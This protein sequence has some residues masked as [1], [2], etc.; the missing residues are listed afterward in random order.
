MAP[1]REEPERGVSTS[2]RNS[3]GCLQTGVL[4]C[5]PA[6][7][8]RPAVFC[9]RRRHAGIH[10]EPC[11][12]SDGA[13]DPPERHAGIYFSAPG[14]PGSKPVCQ[15]AVAH[16]RPHHELFGLPNFFRRLHGNRFG[17]AQLLQTPTT[18][19]YARCCWGWWC[20]NAGMGEAVWCVC[21]LYRRACRC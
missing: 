3:T 12:A 10:P 2:Q 17:V 7:E 15:R 18:H 11:A 21:C 1:F 14:H 9:L 6:K 5:I 16:L 19:A 8:A 13:F 4:S 20:N